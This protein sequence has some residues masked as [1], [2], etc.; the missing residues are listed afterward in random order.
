MI[1]E[2][3][4]I[5]YLMEHFQLAVYKEM[6]LEVVSA[7]VVRERFVLVW[8]EMEHMHLR[9]TK[10]AFDYL[11]AEEVATL[12]GVLQLSVVDQQEEFHVVEQRRVPWAVVLCHLEHSRMEK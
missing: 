12:G 8:L 4:H 11:A 3:A 6:I 1:Q 7:V 2:Q 5:D 10:M 9:P